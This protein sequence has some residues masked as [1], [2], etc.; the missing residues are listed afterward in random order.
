MPAYGSTRSSCQA[1]IDFCAPTSRAAPFQIPSASWTRAPG[2]SSISRLDPASARTIGLVPWVPVERIVAVGNSAGEGAKIALLSFR[3][4]E[5]ANRIP[6]FIEYVELSGR[7]EFNDI[8]TEVLAFPAAL[9]ESESD[10]AA[11]AREAGTLIADPNR[12][13]ALGAA[14]R[15]RAAALFSA[16]RIVTR[17]VDYYRSVCAAKG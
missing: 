4:R 2:A 1:V 7:G 6:E 3:E 11:L 16:D 15:E 14:G 12:R 17:Y 8:F 9:P 10:T 5:A 13:H